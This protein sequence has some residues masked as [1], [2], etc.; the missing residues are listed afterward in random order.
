MQKHVTVPPGDLTAGTMSVVSTCGRVCFDEKTGLVARRTRRHASSASAS[1]SRMRAVPRKWRQPLLTFDH[2]SVARRER[3]VPTPRAVESGRYPHGDDAFREY[4]ST[5]ARAQ[6]PPL[7]VKRSVGAGEVI[8][9]AGSVLIHGDVQRDAAVRA[10]GDVF[11]WG[12]LLGEVEID[13]DDR[14]EVH[15]MDMRPEVLRIGTAVMEPPEHLRFAGAPDLRRRKHYPEV[16]F[17]D[18]K[19]QRVIID[20]ND[21]SGIDSTEVVRTQKARASVRR[22]A[23]LTGVYIGL[24]GLA[25]M[26]A[27]HVTFSILFNAFDISAT[28]IRVFGV[29]C[30]TFASY[31]IGT[32]YY[33]GKGKGADAF[34]QSTVYG[35]IFVFLA[36]ASITLFHDAQ[37]G[38]FLLGVINA[39]SAYV[40]HRSLRASYT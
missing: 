12:A 8:E 1:S 38:L 9:H 39:V 27:P 15:A 14:A 25:L 23:Y 13:G 37:R 20:A 35:R 4:P 24:A 22:S 29:L 6:A 36:L 33:D 18:E 11:V 28:W 5:T 3:G 19:N 31:Y 21:A 7:V 10:K 16:A 17:L 32:A 2:S 34:Y 30:V 40:M 26:A